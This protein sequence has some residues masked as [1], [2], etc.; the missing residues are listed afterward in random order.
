MFI[1]KAACLQS[2]TFGHGSNR[3]VADIRFT[4]HYLAMNATDYFLPPDADGTDLSPWSPILPSTLRSLRTNL[5]GDSFLV[6]PAGAVHI[7]DRGDAKSNASRPP[8]MRFG[9][10]SKVIA[11]AGSY[12]PWQ[13]SADAQGSCW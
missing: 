11:R 12:V 4:L 1:P 10:Q 6:D 2:T 7:L 3:P 9:A 5:F 13:T 8:K